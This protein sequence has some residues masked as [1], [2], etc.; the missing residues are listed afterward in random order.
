MDLYIVRHAAPAA[1]SGDSDLGDVGRREAAQ[2]GKLFARLGL[3][4]GTVV[5]LS[6]PARRARQTAEAIGS[7]LGLPAADI[8]TFSPADRPPPPSP[9]ATLR[10]LVERLTA[11]DEHVVLVG[12]FGVVN[13]VYGWLVGV[14]D[15]HFQGYGTTAA[16]RCES[17]FAGGSGQLL[18]LVQ[19]RLLPVPDEAATASED[20]VDSIEF[21]GEIRKGTQVSAVDL[22]G[23]RLLL[24]ADETNLVQVLQRDGARF[25]VA[26]D[27]VLD[28]NAKEIDIEG[29]AH[30]GDSVYV[31]G[32]H[33][34]KRKKVKPTES[35]EENRKALRKVSREPDREAVFRFRLRADGTA[36]NLDSTTLRPF[37][38]GDP[39]LGPYVGIPGKENGI[40]LEGLA[41]RD[42]RLYVGCRSPVLREQL[43]PV[44]RCQFATPVTDA[45]VLY[46]T[47]GGRGIRDL[48]GL[49]DGFLVLAGPS[50]EGPGSYQLYWWDGGDCLPGTRAGTPAGRL[51]L[52]GEVSPDGG[53]KAEAATVLVEDTAG[54]EVLVV[55]D[56][57][58]AGGP[59]RRRFP[60]P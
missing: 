51:E 3:P 30:D 38:E 58:P 54:Y 39:V 45:E 13:A 44:I 59:I 21:V 23:D 28:P 47:L 18:W 34:C 29:I 4:S 55:F 50:A 11:A 32:S 25:T 33:S 48:A 12:H 31:L 1:T 40:D 2:L 43:V 53:P 6:S 35:V 22:V 52:L 17:S 10:L 19:P 7:A 27:I 49:R 36:K 41:I 24:A 5:V 56:G 57:L 20:E 14:S 8:R 46:L 42:G 37:L 16:V 26:T 15:A 60:R 9:V